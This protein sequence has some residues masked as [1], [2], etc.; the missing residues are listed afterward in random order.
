M[1]SRRVNLFFFALDL[2]DAHCE[3]GLHSFYNLQARAAG[4]A[5]K[6]GRGPATVIG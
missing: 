6:F 1:K 5:V 4:K 3:L 2:F